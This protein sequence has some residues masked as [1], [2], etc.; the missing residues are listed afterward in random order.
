[1]NNVIVVIFIYRLYNKIIFYRISVNNI[2]VQINILV[3]QENIK[4]FQ[5]LYVKFVNVSLKEEGE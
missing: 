1:M 5:R 4:W 2:N 3:H